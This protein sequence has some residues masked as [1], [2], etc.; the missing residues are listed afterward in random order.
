MHKTFSNFLE[1]IS[2]RIGYYFSLKQKRNS[3]TGGG[4]LL[5][6]VCSLSSVKEKLESFYEKLQN[7]S[8]FGSVSDMT[9]VFWAGEQSKGSF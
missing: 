9:K 2:C 1:W 7:Q 6:D 5:N 8:V 4:V 3:K